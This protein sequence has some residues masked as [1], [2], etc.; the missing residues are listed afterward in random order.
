MYY[1]D[2]QVAA[3]LSDSRAAC[4]AS[5]VQLALDL[6]EARAALADVR[7]LDDWT[8]AHPDELPAVPVPLLAFV[9]GWC[10]SMMGGEFTGSTPNEARAKAAAWVLE[11][12]K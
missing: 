6:R 4:D 11:Q 10:V 8:A 2:E 12:G 1:S 9:G 3:I 5:T 7:T